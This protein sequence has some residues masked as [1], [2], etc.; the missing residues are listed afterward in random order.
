[1]LA[2]T[3]IQSKIRAYITEYIGTHNRS[4]SY[5][6]MRL[7]FGFASKAAIPHHLILMEKK[8]MLRRPIRFGKRAILLIGATNAPLPR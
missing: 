4:P 7:A 3:P 1:M 2:P 8:D 5:E 6:E